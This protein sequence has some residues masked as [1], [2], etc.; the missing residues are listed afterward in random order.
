MEKVKVI[1]DAC[2]GC[3]SCQAIAPAIF[4]IGDDGFADI[5]KGVDFE[6]ITEEIKK[7][8]MDALDG[9]PTGAI[10]STEE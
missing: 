5:K 9:C 3:G 10:E 7:D 2:I 4:E 1:K 8:I 6:L